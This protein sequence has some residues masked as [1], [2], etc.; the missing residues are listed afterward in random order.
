MGNLTVFTHH[1][2]LKARNVLAKL[3]VSFSYTARLGNV[4]ADGF[5]YFARENRISCIWS[6]VNPPPPDLVDRLGLY[7]F[8]DV[9]SIDPG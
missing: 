7:E 5:S 2:C 9:G 3:N 1:S 6:P 4:L 8:V